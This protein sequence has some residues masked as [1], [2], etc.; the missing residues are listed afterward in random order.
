[1]KPAHYWK[2]RSEQVAARQYMKADRY[3]RELKREYEKAM[4]NLQQQIENFYFKYAIN[5]EVSFQEARKQLSPSELKGFKMTLEEFTE[6]AMNNADGRWTQQLN[7]IYYRTR[8]TRYEALLT[9]IQQQVELLTGMRQ[10]DMRELLGDIYEDTYLQTLFEVQKGTGVGASFARIDD[11]GL[12]MVLSTEF[13]DS[14]WSKRIWGDRDKLTNQIKTKMAQSFIRGETAE[15]SIREVV[16]RMR[17]SLANAERLVQTEAAFFT[18]QATMKGYKESGV[19]E[20]YELVATLDSRTSSICQ[21]LDGK[22]FKLSEM[23]VGVNYPP[24]HVRCRTTTVAYFDDDIDPGDR[25]A[26]SDGGHLYLVPGNMT[27]PEW[28]ELYA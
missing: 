13:E 23:D 16:G 9:Q 5:D 26:E 14:N 24:L 7:S 1:M 2:Q 11:K 20:R 19:I 17:V 22:V 3:E 18:G 15:R 21:S 4:R 27:F 6:K 10:T 8:V 12:N 25:I 28:K